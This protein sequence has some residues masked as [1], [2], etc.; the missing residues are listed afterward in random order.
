MFTY[1]TPRHINNPFAL[2][3]SLRRSMDH[4]FAGPSPFAPFARTR[5]E[6]LGPRIDLSESEESFEL[7]AELPGA[8]EEDVSVTFHEGIVTLEGKRKLEI[9]EGYELRRSE[10]AP[11][12]FVRRYRLGKKVDAD[13]VNASLK[14][15][16]L[17]VTLPKSAEAKPRQIGIQTA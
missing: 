7:V 16:I 10:R 8:R 17:T 1:L 14:D 12:Q 15:G 2:M 3:H 13:N 4:A 9:P 11:L 5:H 6:V